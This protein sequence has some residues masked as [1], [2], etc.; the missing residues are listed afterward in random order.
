M[1]QQRYEEIAEKFGMTSAAVK[2]SAL[3]LRE[4]YRSAMQAIVRQTIAEAE[5]VDAELNELLSALRG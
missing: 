5:T 2:V 1:T 3:R 4:K